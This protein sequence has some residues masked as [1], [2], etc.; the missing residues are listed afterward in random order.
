MTDHDPLD[1]AAQARTDAQIAEEERLARE[2]QQS[3]TRWAMSTKQGRRF[4]HRQLCEAGIW[5]TVFDT[6]PATMAFKEGNR[7]RG[8][9]L[10]AEINEACPERYLQMLEEQKEATDRY[11][12][13]SADR[14]NRN[15]KR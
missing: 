2:K 1:L 13:R 4:I 8:L 7:N 14:R 5:N 11:E 3:D 9:A 10:L 12:H 15:R 6:D